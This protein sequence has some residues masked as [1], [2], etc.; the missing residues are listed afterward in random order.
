MQNRTVPYL[1]IEWQTRSNLNGKVAVESIFVFRVIAKSPAERAGVQVGDAVRAIDG[2]PISPR[3]NLSALICT[4]L[5]GATLTLE[6]LRGDKKVTIK[7]ALGERQIAAF[8]L[9]AMSES[10]NGHEPGEPG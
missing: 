5:P 1:G 8:K 4:K 2:S 10:S 7:V 6:L 9:R 3:A